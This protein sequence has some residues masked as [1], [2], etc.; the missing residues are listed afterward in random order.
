MVSQTRSGHVSDW[1]DFRGLKTPFIQ[2]NIVC[3]KITYIIHQY[4]QYP[5]I[6][7]YYN[8]NRTKRFH[9]GTNTTV[10]GMLYVRDS[11]PLTVQNIRIFAKESY[12]PV[13]PMACIEQGSIWNWVEHAIL[14]HHLNNV[15][16]P[17]NVV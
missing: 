3:T 4:P 6:L 17:S 13:M 15:L 2:L 16:V 10:I 11:P 5:P 7:I 12:N 8:Q 14:F 1:V 9:H